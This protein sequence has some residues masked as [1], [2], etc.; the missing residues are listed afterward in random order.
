M[1]P[2]VSVPAVQLTHDELPAL[3]PRL[4]TVLAGHAVTAA[5][6]HQTIC[7]VSHPTNAARTGARVADARRDRAS[8]AHCIPPMHR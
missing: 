6:C 7:N 4:A 3:T 1:A 8:R 5:S 2:A